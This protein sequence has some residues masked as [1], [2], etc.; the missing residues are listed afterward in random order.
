MMY[1]QWAM[2]QTNSEGAADLYLTAQCATIEHPHCKSLPTNLIPHDTV[3]PYLPS[4]ARQEQVER[5]YLGWESMEG[6]LSS[7]DLCLAKRH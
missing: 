7:V 3:L 2:L 4:R 5:S 6:A 1:L